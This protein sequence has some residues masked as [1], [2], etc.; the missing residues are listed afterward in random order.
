MSTGYGTC[1]LDELEKIQT[2]KNRTYIYL[3]VTA[4]IKESSEWHQ[5]DIHL[6]HLLS[7]GYQSDVDTNSFA[8]CHGMQHLICVPINVWV[9]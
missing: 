9:N 4:D 2:P 5:I 8:V 7:T 1:Y 6:T 3:G